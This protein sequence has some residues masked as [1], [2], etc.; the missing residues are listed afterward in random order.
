MDIYVLRTSPDHR[1][2]G[3]NNVIERLVRNTIYNRRWVTDL[4]LFLS[5]IAL[6]ILLAGNK[7]TYNHVLQVG[8]QNTQLLEEVKSCTDPAGACARR[9]E[10]VTSDAVAQI[11]QISIIAAY[12]ANKQP[13]PVSSDTVRECVQKE[14]NK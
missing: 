4:L 6:I 8:E 3:D 1:D 13:V 10:K 9:G 12:C 14:L 11:K 2:G 5:V 7:S